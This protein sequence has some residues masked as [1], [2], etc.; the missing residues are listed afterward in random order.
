[1]ASQRGEKQQQD[2]A[3]LEEES[4][5]KEGLTSFAA[6]AGPPPRWLDGGHRRWPPG[7]AEKHQIGEPPKEEEGFIVGDAEHPPPS[8][9]QLPPPELDS[10]DEER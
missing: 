9:T 4:L 3:A 2:P 7:A 1:M 8:L 6:H 10:E 5:I